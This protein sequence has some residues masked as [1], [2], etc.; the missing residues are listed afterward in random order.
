MK[1]NILKIKIIL[2]FSL[3]AFSFS[4]VFAQV[5]TLSKVRVTY[6]P[7]GGVSITTFVA[8]AC[9]AGETEEQCRDREMQKNPELA[10]LPHDDILLSE[11]PQDRKDRNKWTGSKGQGIWI[12]HSK[13][14]KTEKLEELENQLDVAINNEDIIQTAKLQRLI[15]KLGQYNSK[16]GL[17]PLQDLSKFDIDKPLTLGTIETSSLANVNFTLP[18]QTLFQKLLNWFKNL[19]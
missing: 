12:D 6:R 15:K 2:F 13:I 1:N 5:P 3:F 17:I 11:L 14:T 7:D 4:L 9:Q 19:L 18:K 8:G 10:N 16:N